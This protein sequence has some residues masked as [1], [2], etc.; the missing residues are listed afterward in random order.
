[1]G[2]HLFSFLKGTM[3][4]SSEIKICDTSQKK[5]AIGIFEWGIGDPIQIFPL[6]EL[7]K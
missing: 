3:C 2:E 6:M 4:L 1:M 7:Q 5:Y